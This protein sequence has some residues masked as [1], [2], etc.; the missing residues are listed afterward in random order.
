MY[1]AAGAAPAET[2]V[3]V[4]GVT[5]EIVVVPAP[6]CATLIL[7]PIDK[8]EIDSLQLIYSFSSM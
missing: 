4:P 5:A 3:V 1:G 6:N 2:E 7:V 8:L